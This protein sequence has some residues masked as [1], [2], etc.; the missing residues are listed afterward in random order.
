MSY[1]GYGKRRRRDN[2][3]YFVCSCGDECHF[4]QSLTC[5]CCGNIFCSDC[6]GIECDICKDRERR[7][8]DVFETNV[9][10][11]CIAYPGC[12]S[13]GDDV[14]ICT[15]C[16]PEHLKTCSKKSRAERVISSATHKI[17]EFE[18]N[19]SQVRAEIESK[20]ARLRELE[21]GLAAA[22]ARKREAETERA[23][24]GEDSKEKS[25]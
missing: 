10:E 12:D 24:E 15:G 9:C 23:K 20:Q 22:Q 11:S 13:C 18:T 19:I 4:D 14:T 3:D 7:G 17:A 2:D 8:Q 5:G 1:W 16:M 25:K 21:A 6:A